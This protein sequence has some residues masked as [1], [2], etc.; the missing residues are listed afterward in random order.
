VIY[1]VKDGHAAKRAKREN[2]EMWK[3]LEMKVGKEAKDI[4]E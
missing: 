3:K 2:T 1:V 4:K